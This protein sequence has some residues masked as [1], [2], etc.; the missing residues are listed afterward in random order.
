MKNVRN[1]QGFT[2][3]ELM[4]VIAILAILLAIAVP[5][6]QNYSIRAN[7]SECVNTAANVKLAVSETAQTVGG[8]E[9]L[10][11]TFSDLGIAQATDLDTNNCDNWTLAAEGV[12]SVDTIEDE[13]G[14]AIELTFT[15]NQAS[16][17]SPIEW[18]CSV[19]G[20][21]DYRYVPAEC[22]NTEADFGGGE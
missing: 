11:T 4:I 2:L 6:Y 18:I 1:Q 14:A 16:T 22:R 7:V 5:Q 3:I 12:F 20:E 21:D 13:V 10:P 17:G 9:N 19:E 8:L 15:P